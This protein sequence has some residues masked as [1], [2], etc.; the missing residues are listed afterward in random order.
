MGPRITAAWGGR[1]CLPRALLGGSPLSPLAPPFN[2]SK[3]ALLCPF[4]YRTGSLT[5]GQLLSPPAE[6]VPLT[7]A[8]AMVGVTISP[9]MHCPSAPPPRPH[10]GPLCAHPFPHLRG[11][12]TLHVCSCPAKSGLYILYPEPPCPWSGLPDALLGQ[13]RHMGCPG[14][15]GVTKA[16]GSPKRSSREV[17][18]G[19]EDPLG[20]S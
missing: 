7:V 9:S 11:T 1:G 6:P 16:L 17:H 14:S 4:P 8:P 15:P 19:L 10:P 13:D 18:P 5:R 2:P 12:Q 3:E 20:P